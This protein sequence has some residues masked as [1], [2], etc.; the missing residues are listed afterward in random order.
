MEKKII[1]KWGKKKDGKMLQQ[2]VI[3]SENGKN[4]KGKKI[5]SSRTKHEPV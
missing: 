5:Y 1:S 2:V 3:I 4:A